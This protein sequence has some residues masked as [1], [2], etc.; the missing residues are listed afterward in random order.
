MIEINIGNLFINNHN[1]VI[2]TVVKID[3]TVHGAE[4]ITIEYYVSGIFDI[5]SSNGKI[6]TETV[7]RKVIHSAIDQGIL[8]KI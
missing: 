8:R 6:I 2:G 5:E 7:F 3:D 4:L 1:G